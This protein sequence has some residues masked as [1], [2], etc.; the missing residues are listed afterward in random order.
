MDETERWKV[1]PFSLSDEA[2]LLRSVGKLRKAVKFYL[3]ISCFLPY[4]RDGDGTLKRVISP[5]DCKKMM[6]EM[7]KI[8][9]LYK[10]IGTDLEK[11]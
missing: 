8:K 6:K 10:Q 1:S 9:E 2:R 4:S 11:V 5:E 7:E 3:D